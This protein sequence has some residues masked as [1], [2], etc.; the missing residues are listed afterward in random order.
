MKVK[1]MI[2]LFLFLPFSLTVFSQKK[3][4]NDSTRYA[5]FDHYN[6]SDY[7]KDA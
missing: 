3:V 4:G 2:G 1:K 6:L 5:L 7:H